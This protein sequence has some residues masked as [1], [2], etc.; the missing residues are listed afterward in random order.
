[1]HPCCCHVHSTCDKEKVSL[2]LRNLFLTTSISTIEFPTPSISAGAQEDDS[3]SIL[4]LERPAAK[5]KTKSK[6]KTKGSSSGKKSIKSKTV[7]K[8]SDAAAAVEASTPPPAETPKKGKSSFI[9]KFLSRKQ[10][11]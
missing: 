3:V 7:K 5:K 10:Q 6:T 2:L 8:G 11:Q 1:M 9:G 4:G